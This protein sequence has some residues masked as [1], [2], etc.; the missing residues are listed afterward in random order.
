MP[1]NNRIYVIGHANPDTDSIA[2]A[3]GYAWLLHDQLEAE[4]IAAR[5]GQLNPQTTWVLN[6][7][8]LE[9]PLLLPDASPRFDS[10]T[11]RYNTTTPERPLRDAWAIANRTGGIAPIIN[12]DGTPYGLV[13]VLSL[14]DFLKRSV[15]ASPRREEMRIG[16]LLDVPCSE[17]CDTDVPRFQLNSRIRDALPRILREERTEFWAVDEHG[18][19]G[20]VCR[21][22]DAL[23]PPRLQLIL[24]DHN[25]S[26]QALGALDEA[27]LLEILDHHRLGNPSTHTPIRFT[28]DVVG[29][30]CTL[31]SE[32]IDEAGLSAPPTLAGLLLAGLVSD[33]LLLTSPTTTS[34]DHSAADRLARWA[35]M[36]GS[37][38]EGETVKSFGEQVLQAGAGLTF[39]APSEIVSADFKLYDAGGLH[40]GIAQVEVTNFAQLE[41]HREALQEALLHLCE[42]K[43][44]DFSMLMVTDVVRGSSRLLLTKLLPQLEVLPYPHLPD[45]TLKAEGVVSRK[46]QLLPIVLGALEG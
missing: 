32:R 12:P 3:M 4:V 31:V 15:G 11:H 8:Q 37:V 46:K 45:G 1:Q 16:E 9:P 38:L 19:Y 21:Q 23:N 7:L 13:T 40:F 29:S 42:S 6:R 43:A 34:R 27:D 24:V 35:F 41:E 26:R 36:G 18:S 20:G 10:I 33:T 25:E 2:A 14:F 28:V 5:A 44:L 30:T 22:R 39:R 17:A